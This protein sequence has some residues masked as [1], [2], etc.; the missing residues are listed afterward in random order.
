VTHLITSSSSLS[1]LHCQV[2]LVNFLSFRV[3]A[4][5]CMKCDLMGHPSGE[6]KL[7]HVGV[8]K[9][10][11]MKPNIGSIIDVNLSKS[12]ALGTR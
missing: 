11:N 1:T 3:H 2:D 6:R 4:Y 7:T 5:L 9:A 12:P 10:K 8:R